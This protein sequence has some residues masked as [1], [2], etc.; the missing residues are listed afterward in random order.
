M[1]SGKPV[2]IIKAG[3]T[4]PAIA[5]RRGDFEDWIRMGMALEPD[6][7]SVVDV[8]A[9][10][11]LP[12]PDACSAAVVTG[13]HGMVTDRAE[14]S[15]RSAEWLSRAQRDGVPVL[16][17][18]Y[19]HQLLAH[20][21]GGEIADNPRGLEYGTVETAL[22]RPA[23][24]DSLLR[25]LPIKLSVQTGH[26]QAVIRLPKGAVL[27]AQSA[28]DSC[29]AFRFGDAAWGVQFHPEFDADIMREYLGHT[30]D[31][32]EKAGLDVDALL[33]KV[34]STDISAAILQ[35][36]RRIAAERSGS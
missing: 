19:G 28:R 17:I 30:R 8:T 16:G 25:G 35:R 18:C 29:H 31:R 1:S 7:V 13:S 22:E 27:L 11:P 32:L 9:G 34:Q 6:E 5:E 2:L 15:E 14:W 26:T 4:L 36:F 24:D 33:S 12:A 3:S 10:D 20:A 23:S 21:L